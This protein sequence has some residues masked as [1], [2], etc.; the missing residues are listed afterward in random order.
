MSENC[1]YIG[2]IFRIKYINFIDTGAGYFQF[3]PFIDNQFSYIWTDEWFVSLTTCESN[4]EHN[5][6]SLSMR[7][8]QNIIYYF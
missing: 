4:T 2:N 8:T 7:K 5:L 6:K 1:S 3:F